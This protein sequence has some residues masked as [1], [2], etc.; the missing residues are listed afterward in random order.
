ME[1]LEDATPTLSRIT[2]DNIIS[3]NRAHQGVAGLYRVK[4][5]LL[6]PPFKR[7]ELNEKKM[8]VGAQEWRVRT[9]L[10]NASHSVSVSRADRSPTSPSCCLTGPPLP[11][12]TWRG[13]NALLL[14][15]IAPLL[16]KLTTILIMICYVL[17]GEK[18]MVWSQYRGSIRPLTPSGNHGPV[19]VQAGP[20][21]RHP[22]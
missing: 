22:S 19:Q 5:H 9:G 18:G 1:T 17:I 12:S 8:P 21:G 20:P 11:S 6:P 13:W 7:S 2:H 3:L 16:S 10:I 4:G 14:C 15:L